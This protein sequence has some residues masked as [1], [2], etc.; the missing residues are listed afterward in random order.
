MLLSPS[1]V[2]YWGC[3]VA[4]VPLQEANIQ[5]EHISVEP[6]IVEVNALSSESN[7]AVDPV[8]V[9]VNAFSSESNIASTS[10]CTETF[11]HFFCL[12]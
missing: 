5:A 9:E 1:V 8:I 10:V 7:I 3:S 2:Y 6:V 11:H 4:F 12:S